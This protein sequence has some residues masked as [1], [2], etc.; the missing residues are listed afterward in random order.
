MIEKQRLLNIEAKENV[1]QQTSFQVGKDLVSASKL[2][3]WSTGDPQDL[4][5]IPV[6]REVLPKNSDL[7]SG[8]SID[9]IT[10]EI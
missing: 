1:S 2:K 3:D 4:L 10:P 8:S 9:R 5:T 6:L 7:E